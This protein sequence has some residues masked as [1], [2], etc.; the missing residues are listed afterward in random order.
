MHVLRQWIKRNFAACRSCADRRNL[1]VK[2]H[3]LFRNQVAAAE[4]D[5]CAVYIGKFA[6]DG[7]ALA[8]VAEAPR[9]EDDWQAEFIGGLREVRARVDGPEAWHRYLQMLEERLL[10]HP[11]LCV[12]EGGRGRIDDSTRG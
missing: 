4:L 10:D 12:F 8:V 5:D 6:Y 2:R 7:L 1:A 11:V 9:L 3:P